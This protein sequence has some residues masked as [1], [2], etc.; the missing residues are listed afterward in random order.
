MSEIMTFSWN[1]NFLICFTLGHD[2]IYFHI[3]IYMWEALG[4]LGQAFWNL[5]ISY[6][7]EKGKRCVHEKVNAMWM[8]FSWKS[9]LC[10]LVG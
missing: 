3:Y 8:L 6:D 9:M 4:T 2:L 5:L 1:L 7:Y 10:G